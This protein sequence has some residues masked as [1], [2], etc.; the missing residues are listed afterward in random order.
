MSMPRGG[1]NFV[2]IVAD[3]LGWADLGCYGSRTPATPHLDAL[4]REGVRFTHGY[5]NSA[6]CSPTRFALMTGRW[7]YRLRGA[8]EEPI[9]GSA[10]GSSTVGLPPSHPTFVSLL[11]DAGWR[12]ALVGKWHLG[13]P[14]HFGP[15][16]SGYDT[17]F[18][19]LGGGLDYFTH[20]DRRG[21]HDLF[22]NADPVQ[23]DGYLTDVLTDRAVSFVEDCAARGER[24]ALSLHYTA[25]HWPWEAREDRAESDRIRSDIAHPDGGSLATYMRMVAQMDEG[26]GRVLDALRDR[27]LRDDTMVVF[28]SD[29]GGERFSD[30]WPF[31]GRKLDLLEGGIRVP[32]IVRW[33][34]RARAGAVSD[35]VAITMDIAPTVLEAAGLPP[36]PAHPPDGVSLL[37]VLHAPDR[38][39]ERDLFWRMK[40]RGQRAVRSG[41]WKLLHLDGH[42]HLFDL[43]GDG[44]ETVNLIGRH[45]EIAQ[46]LQRRFDAWAS[47][48][49]PVP[50]DAHVDR[51]LPEGTLPRPSA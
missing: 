38:T 50:D 36:A 37:P 26:I 28:T 40:H 19:A 6:L 21:R 45:P 15:N 43:S 34:G 1:T 2:V 41:R 8:A 3:D 48:M 12:T 27:G 44:R 17:F 39:I 47:T 49:P 32:W 51:L 14:P 4:A 13:Y 25:P 5:A 11:R 31:I 16:L 23:V 24:F 42:V 10:R 33:P 22:E 46:D 20:C 7:Q 29:N 9:L 18:G 35:Q 30:A